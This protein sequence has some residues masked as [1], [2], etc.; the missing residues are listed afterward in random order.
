VAQQRFVHV[1]LRRVGHERRRGR[2][3]RGLCVARVC[4]H[5]IRKL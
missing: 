2:A 3:G 4:G 5:R 1:A